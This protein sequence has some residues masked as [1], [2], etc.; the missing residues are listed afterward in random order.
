MNSTQ[1]V[2]KC[3]KILPIYCTRLNLKITSYPPNRKP[4]LHTP[5]Q[6]KRPN[7]KGMTSTKGPANL[8]PKLIRLKMKMPKPSKPPRNQKVKLQKSKKR[9]RRTKLPFKSPNQPQSSRV[10]RN[11]PQKLL[12]ISSEK[13]SQ[14]SPKATK[15][16]SAKASSISLLTPP[17]HPR[18][19]QGMELV[20]DHKDRE[21][22]NKSPQMP[23]K[24]GHLRSLLAS[25]KYNLAMKRLIGL[26]C[27]CCSGRVILTRGDF[28]SSLKGTLPTTKID[29][30]LGAMLLNWTAIKQSYELAPKIS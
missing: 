13:M 5:L 29:C 9:R 26:K 11:P 6:L 10:S 23:I 28:T 8:R 27:I 12:D 22:I 25:L 2:I 24:T 21:Q 17:K 15:K 4:P 20:I 30:I 16:K 14:A 19:N 7:S 18:L 3:L 1:W